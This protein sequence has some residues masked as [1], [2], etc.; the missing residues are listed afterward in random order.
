MDELKEYLRALPDDAA[1]E[2]FA[3]RCGTSLGHMRNTFYGSKR[4]APPT[5]V[6]V[7]LHTGHKV[8]RWHTRPEDWREIWPELIG[9]GPQPVKAD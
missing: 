5:C 1:R 8:R 7:E 4:L 2:A 9:I 6:L 3:K